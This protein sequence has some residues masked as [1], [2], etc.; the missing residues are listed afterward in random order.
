MVKQLPECKL[1]LDKLKN[2][3]PAALHYHTIEHTLDVYECALALAKKEGLRPS[4][5]KL[6]LIA[7]IYHDAGYL[8]QNSDHEQASCTIAQKYLPQFHYNQQDIDAIC[9]V[10]MATKIPQQP[11]SL[12]EEIICDADLDY[13]GR[14]DFFSTGDKLYEEMLVL[15][16][17]KNREQWNSMQLAFLQQHHYFTSTA[18]RL[19]QSQK[20]KNLKVVQSKI[21]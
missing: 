7:A 11:H 3:L 10:I 4:D 1:I 2:E 12:L 19:R 20:E 16:N 15:G 5:I 8:E 14:D 17:V 6:L 13:L 9:S 21:K 18:L